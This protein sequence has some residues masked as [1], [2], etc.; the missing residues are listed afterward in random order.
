MVGTR[1]GVM[2]DNFADVFSQAAFRFCQLVLFILLGCG[3]GL[4]PVTVLVEPGEE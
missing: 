2:M 4:G 3:Q 1:R